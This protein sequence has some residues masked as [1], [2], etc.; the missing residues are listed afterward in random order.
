MKRARVERRVERVLCTTCKAGVVDTELLP[1]GHMFHSTCLL[2]WLAHWQRCPLCHSAIEGT[3]LAVPR[4]PISTG[5]S[6]SY[7]VLPEP[8]SVQL[9]LAGRG[10]VVPALASMHL[11]GGLQL[12]LAR[13]AMAIQAMQP[14]PRLQLRADA[15]F[16]TLAPPV[17]SRAVHSD[18]LHAVQPPASSA[19]GGGAAAC[20]HAF[21]HSGGAAVVQAHLVDHSGPKRM[22]TSAPGSAAP[23]A[24]VP[25]HG[26]GHPGTRRAPG[27]QMLQRP[28]GSPLSSLSLVPAALSCSTYYADQ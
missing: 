12:S 27:G 23:P 20:L 25:A 1:C 21:H 28:L 16:A 15:S 19:S 4:P 9:G 26:M 10:A 24:P 18:A 22:R 13:R 6:V 14:P 17:P 3:A 11:R 7:M 5:T 8:S 2:R